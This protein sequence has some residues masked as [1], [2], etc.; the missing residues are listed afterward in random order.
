MTAKPTFT[1]YLD[2]RCLRIFSLGIASGFPWVLI[3]S[4]LSL[5][6]KE[7]G[8]SRTTIGYAGLIFGVYAINF[9]WAPLVDRVRL[10][11]LG[12]MGQRRGY[13]LLGQLCVLLGCL[14]LSQL[15][16][17]Q[18]AQPVV[19][20][21]LIIAIASASQDIA[22]DAYRIDSLPEHE[23]DL[24]AAGAAM[25]TAGWWTGYAG[26]GFIPFWLSDASSL[27]WAS[28]GLGFISSW[29]SSLNW[30]NIYGL[31][32][33]VPAL[34][35]L[36]IMLAP[37]PQAQAREAS[38]AE[39]QRLYLSAMPAISSLHKLALG[40]S[41]FSPLALVI[42]AFSGFKGLPVSNW[43]APL[44]LLAALLLLV[45]IGWQL[46]QLERCLNTYQSPEPS[47]TV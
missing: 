20:V 28:I 21:C 1:S 31:M 3:G 11:L 2:S 41:L 40:L 34:L 13:M 14:S 38:Q 30:A 43:W 45:A 33:V 39:Q 16:F 46:R 18:S 22:I 25:A 4:M 26:L 23:P 12:G 9:L 15:D 42:W 5:A 19:L 10:P 37:E 8:F 29:L 44:A 36:V 17:S 7:Y 24:Q 32:A 27:N 6:L 47:P 35:T